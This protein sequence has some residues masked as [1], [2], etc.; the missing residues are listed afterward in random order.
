MGLA[1][2]AVGAALGDA[3]EDCSAGDDRDDYCGLGVA[4]GAVFLGTAGYTVGVAAGVS[5]VDPHDRF[6]TALAGSAAGLTAGLLL[7][8]AEDPL[9]PFVS[10]AGPIIAATAISE[11]TR[12][13]PGMSRLSFGLSPAPGRGVA[14]A[15]SL[16]F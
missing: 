15:A 2:T 5:R 16:R 14:A 10:F 13:P 3:A 4:F 6:I 7:G 12:A 9:W 11:L 1:G 8:Y